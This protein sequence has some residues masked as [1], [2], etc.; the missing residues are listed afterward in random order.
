MMTVSEASRQD[1]SNNVKQN[2]SLYMMTILSDG[3]MACDMRLII[4]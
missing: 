3:I 1:I 4:H 2:L